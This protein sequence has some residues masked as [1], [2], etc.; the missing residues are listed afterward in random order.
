ME[1]FDFFG[2]GLILSLFLCPSAFSSL[3]TLAEIRKQFNECLKELRKR[4]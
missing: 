4:G 1:F 3:F 2:A